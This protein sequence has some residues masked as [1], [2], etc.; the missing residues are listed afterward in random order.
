MNR[1]DQCLARDL[2]EVLEINALAGK[3]AG[4]GVSDAEVDQQHLVVKLFASGVAL[5]PPGVRT[6]RLF[7]CIAPVVAAAHEPTRTQL[8]AQR[9]RTTPE[10]IRVLVTGPLFEPPNLSADAGGPEHCGQPSHVLR[11][12]QDISSRPPDLSGDDPHHPTGTGYDG[13]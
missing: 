7:G 13:A 3:P 11:R 4:E 12:R 6:A 10:V 2:F 8:L 5:F 1:L 9:S